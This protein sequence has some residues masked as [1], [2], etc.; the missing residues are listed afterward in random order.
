MWRPPRRATQIMYEMMDTYTAHVSV[1]KVRSSFKTWSQFVVIYCLR[2]S[3]K[4]WFGISMG[5]M[6]TTYFKKP[7]SG[8]GLS[9]Q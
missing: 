6:V 8:V 7:L 3:W 4:L 5:K 1:A 9:Q 2:G